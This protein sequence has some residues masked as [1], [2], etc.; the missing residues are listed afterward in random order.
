MGMDAASKARVSGV[1]MSHR[2]Y[3]CT[4]SSMEAAMPLEKWDSNAGWI[5]GKF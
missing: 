1:S 2:G 4:I 3:S 5:A